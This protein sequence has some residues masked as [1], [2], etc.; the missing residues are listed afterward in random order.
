M[1]D[2]KENRSVWTSAFVVLVVAFF[3]YFNGFDKP[4]SVFWDENYHIASS[5]KYIDGVM[6][7]EPHPP[8]GK[9]LM[10]L[11]ESLSG[12]NSDI[13]K[14]GFS[15]TDY[16]KKFPEG[17]QFKAVRLPSAL[18]ATLSALVFYLILYNLSNHSLLSLLFSSMYLFENALIVHSRSAMLEGIQ[19]L[20]LLLSILMFLKM[21]QKRDIKSY[22]WLGIWIGLAVAVKLNALIMILL[23]PFLFLYEYNAEEKLTSLKKW[24]VGSVV[25]VTALIAVFSAVFYIHIALGK[26]IPTHKDYEMSP[27]YKSVLEKGES[28]NIKHLFPLI[29]ENLKFTASY[30]KNVPHY[31][32]CKKGE[33]G[34]LFSTWPFL[35]K[36]INYRWEKSD[37]KVKYLYLMGNPVIWFGAFLGVLLSFVLVVAKFVFGLRVEKESF[38]PIA[39][40]VTLYL[41]YMIVMFKIERVM[42]LYHYF[43]PLL[44]SMFASFALF[45]HIFRENVENIGK[46]KLF[47]GALFILVAQVVYAFWF[48]SPFTYYEALSSQEFHLREWFEFWK[49]KA[50]L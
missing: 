14:S 44:F 13:D 11:S 43:L 27:M 36:T 20:F 9:L 10:A 38:I 40:F 24:F 1:T 48:F 33:N 31:D 45:V 6:Y 42:Y 41:S 18:M 7:K 49:L 22:V 2:S 15:K 46:N 12:L 5:Q 19:I 4:N 25:S 47:L 29:V 35:N 30:S 21:R 50:I 17:Y 32:P 23:L 3:T 39:L 37:G 26:N 34:S 28:A 8:L 16:I